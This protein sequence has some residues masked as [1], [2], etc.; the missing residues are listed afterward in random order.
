MGLKQPI[1]N[2]FNQVMVMSED[3][4][5]RRNRLALLR[6]IADLFAGL[7]RFDHLQL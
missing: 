1:D 7:A 6:E 2:F 5:L 4:L 3:Q